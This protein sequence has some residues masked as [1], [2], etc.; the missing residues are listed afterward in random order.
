MHL[1]PATRSHPSLANETSVIWKHICL[2]WMSWSKPFILKIH[3]F[4]RLMNT[5]ERI[6]GMGASIREYVEQ[7]VS[8]RHILE[9]NTL[10]H[11]EVISAI[12]SDSTKRWS[13]R[14]RNSTDYSKKEVE[15]LCK[16]LVSGTCNLVISVQLTPAT[17]LL[18]YV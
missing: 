5:S 15:Y 17:V 4:T 13:V 9:S 14:M 2:A 10:P 16:I 3:S 18:I 1:R 6:C 8:Q 7:V 11:T 12:W